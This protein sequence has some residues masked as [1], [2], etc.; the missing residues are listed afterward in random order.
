MARI[1]KRL[2]RSSSEIGGMRHNYPLGLDCC[3]EATPH[4]QRVAT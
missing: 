2:C 3:K 1:D 4:Q